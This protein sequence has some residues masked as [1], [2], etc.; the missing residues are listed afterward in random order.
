MQLKYNNK[1]HF[2]R[3]RIK[4]RSKKFIRITHLKK[5]YSLEK[6][7]FRFFKKKTILLNQTFSKKSWIQNL[8][9]I[10]HKRKKHLSLKFKQ[11]FH[12]NAHTKTNLKV[13]KTT[14]L[15]LRLPS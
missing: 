6:S 9:F 15:K 8:N 2:I 3:F 5:M 10:Q 1:K 13:Q 12:R 7:I 11:I 14:Y 4:K